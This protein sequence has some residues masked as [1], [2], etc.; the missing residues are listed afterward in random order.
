MWGAGGRDAL[1]PRL[2][3]MA[4]AD[5][6]LEPCTH[7]WCGAAQHKR[8]YVQHTHAHVDGYPSAHEAAASE[9]AWLAASDLRRDAPDGYDSR[10]AV[11]ALPSAL[12]VSW[13]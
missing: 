9:L 6:H 1:H 5:Q 13:S 8:A 7:F 4:C 11:W 10:S 3:W 12:G 2:C